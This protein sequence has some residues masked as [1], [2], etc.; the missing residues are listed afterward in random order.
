MWSGP[1]HDKQKVPKGMDR[2]EW[3]IGNKKVAFPSSPLTERGNESLAMMGG[4]LY[5]FPGG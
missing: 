5:H 1:I 4:N 3:E 2:L